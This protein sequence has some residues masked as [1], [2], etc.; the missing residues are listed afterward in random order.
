MFFNRSYNRQSKVWK[1]IFWN[2]Y[3]NF[4]NFFNLFSWL[5]LVVHYSVFIYSLFYLFLERFNF[6]L[7]LRHLHW[8]SVNSWLTLV[9]SKSILHFFLS[10]LILLLLLLVF[11][12]ALGA[13]EVSIMI[14]IELGAVWAKHWSCVI[15]LWFHVSLSCCVQWMNKVKILNKLINY[16]HSLN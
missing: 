3:L 8:L 7:L 9:K 6:Y 5:W 1:N 13:Q 12:E 14:A 2:S 16:I 11:L 15:V 10:W 4:L